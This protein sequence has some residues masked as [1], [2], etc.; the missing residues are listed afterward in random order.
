MSISVVIPAYNATATLPATLQ[1]LMQQTRQPDEIVIVDD[2]STDG[3]GDM[4]RSYAARLPGL[5]V[6]SFAQNQGVSTARNTAIAASRGDIVATLDADDLW[7]PTYLEKMVGRLEQ[8]PAAGF[9]YCFFREIDAQ[10]RVIQQRPNYSASGWIFYQLLNYNFIGNG[11]NTV[12]RRAVLDAVGGFDREMAGSEDQLV[13]LQAAWRSE[14]AHIPEYLV[15]YRDLQTSLSKRWRVVGM[16]NLALP[17]KLR[18]A[19]PGIERA[20][21]RWEISQRH[22]NWSQ[23]LRGR[24][25]GSGREAFWHELLAFAYD[26]MFTLSEVPR[27]FYRMARKAAGRPLPFWT[28]PPTPL[29]GRDFYT[30]DPTLP[31]TVEMQPYRVTELR[32]AAAFDA[33][34]PLR[35]R[36][37]GE[38][39]PVGIAVPT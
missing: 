22:R 2:C 31:V 16:C 20:P 33:A 3:T 1:S 6:I 37:G 19:L 11:S 23:L 26:P 8:M 12:Y 27:R 34:H 21:L 24:Q 39:Q 38:T 36:R 10:D 28:I 18:A 30:I 35:Q 9:V 13:Q 25:L 14:V 17:G 32:R 4:A 7:H 5:K 15:G 29:K